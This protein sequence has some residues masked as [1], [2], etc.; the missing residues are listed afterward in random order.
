MHKLMAGSDKKGRSSTPGS[1]FIIA[2]A[3]PNPPPLPR[4]VIVQLRD[5][6]EMGRVHLKPQPWRASRWDSYSPE[7]QHRGDLVPKGPSDVGQ[8]TNRNGQQPS[9]AGTSARV[10]IKD[11]GKQSQQ[12]P[13]RNR[14][15]ADS[16]TDDSEFYSSVA[17]REEGS[18][19]YEG[20]QSDDSDSPDLEDLVQCICDPSKLDKVGQSHWC[21][22]ADAFKNTGRILIFWSRRTGGFHEDPRATSQRG[23]RQ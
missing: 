15:P 4:P 18:G 16:G 9:Q 21:R 5:H 7:P 13:S 12:Q 14:Y 17:A 22:I 3:I 19:A 10:H 23:H 20:D 6:I 2:S 1:T 8:A 11:N